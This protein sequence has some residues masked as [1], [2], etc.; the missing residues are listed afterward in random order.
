MPEF[1]IRKIELRDRLSDEEKR[2]LIA[3]V[4]TP[5]EVLAHQDIVREGDRPTYSTLVMRGF[6]SRQQVL[7]G[8]ERQITAIHIPGDFVDL[9]SF[10]IKTMDH[11]VRTLTPCTIAPVKHETLREITANY[12]HLA[13]LLW[14]MTLIDAAI[15]R[16]WLTAMGRQSALGQTAHLLCEMCIRQKE[17]G[18]SSGS[19]FLMPLSQA[20]LADVLGLSTV[21]TNRVVRELRESACVEWQGEQVTVKS[22]DRLKELAE[23]DATYLSLQ[24]EPR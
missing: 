5:K 2:V 18:L 23:F 16:R 8:G 4:G 11:G 19:A 22:W 9:H 20:R 24:N 13:R 10:L 17:I 21:H 12:P 7:S 15:H 6:T 14:L 3:A 1:L